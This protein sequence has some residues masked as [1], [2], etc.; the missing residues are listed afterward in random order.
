TRELLA[1]AAWR[2]MGINARRFVD[3]LLLEHMQH[4]GRENGHL[5]APYQQLEAWGIGARLITG[6]IQ[7]A[8]DLGLVVRRRGE[9]RAPNVYTLTWL[10]WSDGDGTPSNRWR[11]A[12]VPHQGEALH[13]PHLLTGYTSPSEGT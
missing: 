6:A 10:P 9:G 5:V 11:S 12:L 7:Q 3:F 8:V 13:I 4:G 1:S 2:A